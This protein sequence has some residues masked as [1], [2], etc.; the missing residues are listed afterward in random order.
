MGSFS[1]PEAAKKM[2]KADDPDY[3]LSDDEF[4]ESWKRVEADRDKV[5]GGNGEVKEV[6]EG[7]LRHR[8]RG[9][10]KVIK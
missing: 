6:N 4:E 5:I 7:K 8:R 10:K 1:N 9:I 2:H 3:Q